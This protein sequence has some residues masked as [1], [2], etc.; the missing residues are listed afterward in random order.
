[1]I[2]LLSLIILAAYQGL[3]GEDLAKFNQKIEEIQ[4]SGQ[5]WK[6][7][8]FVAGK[9]IMFTDPKMRP[10]LNIVLME[11]NW[12]RPSEIHQEA[13]FAI[14]AKNQADL[15]F[16]LFSNPNFI[17]AVGL[18]A[19]HPTALQ[20]I[21]LDVENLDKGYAAFQFFRNG[22]WRAVIVDTLVP[23]SK[24][25]KSHLLCH[26]SIY[27]ELWLPLLEKAYAKLHGSFQN[28]KEIPTSQI[29]TE[30][31]GGSVETILFKEKKL[32]EFELFSLVEYLLHH[33]IESKITI[34]GCVNRV[35]E[36]EAYKKNAGKRGIYDDHY[37]GILLAKEYKGWCAP[38]VDL[39]LLKIRN[40]WGAG[41]N[42]SGN[43]C[44]HGEDWDRAKLVRED[45]RPNGLDREYHYRDFFMDSADLRKKFNQLVVCRLPKP[46]SEQPKEA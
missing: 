36:N 42:W 46:P 14:H 40:Y 24:T 44:N 9:E 13:K 28:I 17:G 34:L 43:W 38:D 39:R 45:L 8:K 19:G 10:I 12:Q 23:F 2:L 26:T 22:E 41:G 11:F 21:F 20:K 35:Q 7:P 37:Y 29:L 6:D 32:K 5:E 1:M 31:T 16:G 15:N 18:L 27:G 3:S 33:P 4:A 25:K 30:L